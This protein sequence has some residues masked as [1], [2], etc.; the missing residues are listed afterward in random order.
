MSVAMLG[1]VDITSERLQEL[2]TAAGMQAQ[3]DEDG[4]LCVSDGATCYVLPTSAGDR[5]QLM[6]V[7]GTREAASREACLELANRVNNEI[8]TVRA[9]VTPRGSLVFDYH[10]PIDGGTSERA[11]VLAT[12]FFLTAALEAIR[13]CDQDDVVS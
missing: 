5:I 9:R 12:R 3:I 10:I 8:S 1:P 2:Y 7:V 4:D 11:V 6:A 13:R